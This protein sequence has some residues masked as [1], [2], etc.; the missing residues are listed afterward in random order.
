LILL[1]RLYGVVHIPT[2]VFDEV[3]IAGTGMPGAAAVSKAGWIH[4]S[5]V[6]DLESLVKTVAKT[7]LGAGEISAI[8]LAKE[9]A[10]DLII[11]DEWK[12]RKLALEEGLRVVGCIGILEELCRRGE[13]QDLRQLYRELLSQN[14]R[15]DLRTLQESLKQ[16]G[17]E[18]L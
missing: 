10:A 14:I 2:E 18:S 8:F 5:A 7:G 11:M 15:I 6:Q 12:G 13:I 17:L 16:F 1:R 4:V 9:V 3:V